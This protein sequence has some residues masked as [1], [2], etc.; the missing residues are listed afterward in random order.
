[1]CVTRAASALISPWREYGFRPRLQ[2]NCHSVKETASAQ[3]LLRAVDQ[4]PNDRPIRAG[5]RSRHIT[6]FAASALQPRRCFRI[7][8]RPPINSDSA[9]RI[10]PHA[11]CSEIRAPVPSVDIPS[12]LPRIRSRLPYQNRTSLILRRA[13]VHNTLSTT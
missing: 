2:I 10:F 6:G 7:M 12:V 11:R 5:I 9:T 13:V 8:L 4:Y 3:I 1:M